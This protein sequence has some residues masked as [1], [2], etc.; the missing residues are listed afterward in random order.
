MLDRQMRL[1]LRVGAAL[2]AL[3]ALAALFLPQ[4]LAELMKLPL[5]IDPQ[6]TLW[7]IR[8]SGGIL[9]PLAGFMALGA[10]FL[11]ERALRQSG[12]ILVF[13]A[14]L[15]AILLAIA[16]SPWGWGR[17]SFLALSLIIVAFAVK[18]LRGR[19]RHR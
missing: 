18:A 12:G 7:N 9:L 13:C 8:I 5:D 6:V 16:P 1:L 3:S 11:P 4:K 10:A 17:I 2:I 14:G 15:L 19:L